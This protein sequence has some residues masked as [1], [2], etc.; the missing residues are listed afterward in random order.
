MMA[1]REIPY[2]ACMFF[3]AGWMRDRL[4]ER[5]GSDGVGL[6]MTS[7][8]LTA[9]IAGPISHVPSVVAAYQ[10]AHAISIG[11]ACRA[12]SKSGGARGFWAGLLPRT[13]SLAGSLFVFPF[14]VEQFQPLLEKW[15]R[16]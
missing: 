16:R 2:A 15:L 13:A 5:F 8:T 1:G 10:Q 7:A 11:D 14:S 12:I 6:Q 3:L 4:T 9:C